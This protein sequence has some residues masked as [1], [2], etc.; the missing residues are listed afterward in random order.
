MSTR[1]SR[2]NS[3]KANS[4]NEEYV[5]LDHLECRFFVNPGR[6][7]D[8]GVV[9]LGWSKASVRLKAEERRKKKMWLH[10]DKKHS[11][12]SLYLKQKEVSSLIHMRNV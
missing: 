4:N 2:E 7:R 8:S 3:Q 11:N 5:N 6:Q 12:L 1:H 9:Y 10:S